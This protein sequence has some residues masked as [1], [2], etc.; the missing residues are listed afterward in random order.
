MK[1]SRQV[2]LFNSSHD[3]STDS[4]N[5]EILKHSDKSILEWRNKI[6]KYQNSIIKN[7]NN[8]SS[9]KSL[10]KNED[11]NKIERL[12]PF[13]LTGSSINFWR[14]NK[15]I[16]DGPAMYFVVDTYKN[17]QIILYVG[18]T[19]SANKRWKGDHD[20]KIYINNYKEALTDNKIDTHIDIRFFLDVPAEIKLR[21]NFEQ[22]LI[23]LWLPPFNKE[24]R[25]RWATT[26][27]N[28]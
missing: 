8:L 16:H 5:N 7:I 25:E 2:E 28:N 1:P 10:I 17:S 24:T 27:T 6:Y 20:C 12:N 4:H 11:S 21:R 9:Q 23:S 15:Y 22:K 19:Y 3:F 26:F 14:S 18:E 13:K